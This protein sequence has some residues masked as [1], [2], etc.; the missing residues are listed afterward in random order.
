MTGGAERADD[1][2]RRHRA[3]GPFTLLGRLGL[4]HTVEVFEARVD[5]ALDAL[6]LNAGGRVA[7]KRLLPHA[8]ET[9]AAV[10]RI[11]R[12]AAILAALAHPSV[13]RAHG[14]LW[15]APGAWSVG[16]GPPLNAR[17]AE[18]LL[19]LELLAG[20]SAAFVQG[21][22]APPER[23]AAVGA[24]AARGLAALHARGL[25]H[26]DVSAS[27]VQVLPSGT[28][29]LIDLGGAAPAG[30]PLPRPP[31]PSRYTSPERAAGAPADP[32]SDLYGL[33]VVLC[34]LA[35]GARQPPGASIRD[36]IP[37]FPAELDR[38][39]ARCL[40]PEPAARPHSASALA[41]ELETWLSGRALLSAP[42]S[43]GRR[44]PTS[45]G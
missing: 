1:P 41:D 30:Q 3:L 42:P 27:N 32:A 28:A 5:E 11:E 9:P 7:L 34:G 35:T 22:S 45:G 2:D 17:A 12:E 14:L 43:A 21:A 37:D 6:G 29:V 18:P 10:E 33:G 31:R 44:P 26:G 36:V 15:W 39:V 19:V 38:L 8:A 20:A 40:A 23:V 4:S 25:V 24:A 13:I 16:A